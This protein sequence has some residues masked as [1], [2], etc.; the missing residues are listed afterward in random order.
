M[1]SFIIMHKVTISKHGENMK[2][3]RNKLFVGNLSWGTDEES[4]KDHFAKIGPVVSVRIVSD[5]YTGKS[6]GFG[7]VEM[8]SADHAQLAIKELNDQPLGDRNLR[9]NLALERSERGNTGG[10][11]QSRERN[12]SR[13]PGRGG[14]RDNQRPYRQ[15]HHERT[16]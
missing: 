4:L 13:E 9:I 15:K 7:F 12:F 11:G 3:G 14:D 10:G 16:Y 1:A 2:E 8:E 5:P 6:K